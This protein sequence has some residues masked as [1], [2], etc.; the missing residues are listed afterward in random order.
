M[1]Q[2]YSSEKKHKCEGNVIDIVTKYKSSIIRIIG[3][4]NGNLREFNLNDSSFSP[5]RIWDVDFSSLSEDERFIMKVHYGLSSLDPVLKEVLWNEFF[6]NFEVYWW[7]DK[8][9]RSTFYR[10]RKKACMEFLS[11]LL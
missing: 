1:N 3:N 5:N 4:A 6:Y 8:F 2:K 7:M 9:S 10:L 11:I